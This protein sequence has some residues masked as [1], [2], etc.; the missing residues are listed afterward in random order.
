MGKARKRPVVLSIDDDED[1]RNLVKLTL[2]PQGYCVVTAAGAEEG[3]ARLAEEKPELIL[4]DVMMPG[5]DGYGFC[6]KAQAAGL[7]S[8]TPIVFMT[9]LSDERDRARA[10]A[11]GAVD[12]VVKPPVPSELV[13]KV[14]HHLLTNRDWSEIATEADHW[15]ERIVPSDFLAFREQAARRF[16]ERPGAEQALRMMRPHDIYASAAAVGISSGEMAEMMADFL[17]LEYMPLVDVS[18][19]ALGMLPVAFCHRN[20]VLPILR[21]PGTAFVLANP[22]NW[23]LLDLLE[24]NRQES[25]SL[26]LIVANPDS[27]ASAFR[28]SGLT[29]HEDLRTGQTADPDEDES[30]SMEDIESRPVVFIANNLIVSAVREGASDVHL[31]PKEAHMEVRFRIDGDMHDMLTLK[32]RTGHMLISRLKALGSMDIAEHRRPQDGMLEADIGGHKL[33]LR[34]ATTSGPYGESMVMRV[35]DTSAP[36]RD[37]R[38]LGMKEEQADRV[39]DYMQRS[40]GMILVV[41]PTGSGKT[42]TVYSALTNIDLD[43]RSLMSVEDPVEYTIARANQQQVNDKAGVTFDSLLKSSV[44]QD[45]DVLYLGEVRDA[46]SARTA[47]DFASTGHLTLSTLHTATATTAIFR[48]E[49]LGVERA[50]MA[51]AV[52][53]IIA[54]RLLKRLCPACKKTGRITKAEREIL[55]PFTDDIP[56]RVARLGPGCSECRRGYAGR[57]GVQ[58]VLGFDAEVAGWIRDGV[59]VGIIR[60]RLRERGDYLMFDHAIDKVRGL[61][62]SIADVEARV[63]IEEETRF[64]PEEPESA[65][66]APVSAEDGELIGEVSRPVAHGAILVVEDDESTKEMIMHVLES[67]GYDTVGVDNGEQAL[68]AMEGRMFDLVLSDLHMPGVDGMQLLNEATRLAPGTRFVMLTG[69]AEAGVEAEALRSGIT[70][71]LYK[72]VRRDVLLLRVARALGG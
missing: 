25:A 62:V 45:P 17:G 12:Y 59:A 57:T 26:S 38:D 32:R 31:E 64:V 18:S 39:R 10:F 33:K 70:D 20:L 27:V 5:T 56:K 66:V 30:L 21:A 29:D 28:F 46:F 43:R 53:A 60:R 11:L 4:L 9:A 7:T 34:L 42:T 55:A 40:Q 71:F 41:G 51:E 58:E 68:L 1:I 6:E 67:A 61:E 37:L 72:P 65:T 35:L 54:Q 47:L 50:M 14:R 22:F 24:R 3:L 44:R 49:R 13:E 15:T 69:S 48:L 36:P 19:I 2:E 8:Y 52:L 16:S 63:L 23:E